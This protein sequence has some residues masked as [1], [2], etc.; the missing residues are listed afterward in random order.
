MQ[1]LHVS[2]DAAAVIYG[3]NFVMA[4]PD[5][6][7]ASSNRQRRRHASS[8][9]PTN[10]KTPASPSK[11]ICGGRSQRDRSQASDDEKY[12]EAGEIFGFPR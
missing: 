4:L 3:F 9:P 10:E 11:F 2:T 12:R 8:V 7:I 6:N 1:A 5:L